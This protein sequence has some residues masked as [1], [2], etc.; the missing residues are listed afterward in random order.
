MAFDKRDI[1]VIEEESPDED[2]L[3]KS[4]M[5]SGSITFSC[6]FPSY[7]KQEDRLSLP[8]GLEKLNVKAP[9]RE[10][11]LSFFPDLTPVH[12]LDE[13]I[14]LMDADLIGKENQSEYVGTIHRN[15]I[16]VNEQLYRSRV[17]RRKRANHLDEDGAN[18]LDED[19]R[20][21]KRMKR[22]EFQ[23]LKPSEKLKLKMRQ[24]LAR[25]KQEDK[26]RSKQ[27]ACADRK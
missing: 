21:P 17:R 12:A 26:K 10:M 4:S 7:K 22:S 23:K 5:K 3:A 24:D 27:K 15:D 19:E 1:T 13:A 2:S 25:G 11:I 6:L 16:S 18:H 8:P 20:L 9:S 14:G